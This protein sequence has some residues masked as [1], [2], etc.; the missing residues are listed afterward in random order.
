MDQGAINLSTELDIEKQIKAKQYARINRRLML[1]DLLITGIY[2][3][4]WLLFGWSQALKQWL[5]TFTSNDWLLVF[6]SILVIGGIMYLINLPLA[7]YQGYILP[8]R[9]DLSN[10]TI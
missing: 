3:L 2:M 9:F 6:L 7:Y 1:I 4:A 10:E 5:L 8:H